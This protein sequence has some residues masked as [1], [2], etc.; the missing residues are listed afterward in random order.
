MF[1]TA[2]SF[3]LVVVLHVGIEVLLVAKVQLGS[4]LQLLGE[5]LQFAEQGFLP[6]DVLF[7]FVG[8]L[9]IG[10]QGIFCDRSRWGRVCSRRI[11]GST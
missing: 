6:F 8:T 11:F 9:G 1:R 3:K 2:P 5:V 4:P 10:S 7:D